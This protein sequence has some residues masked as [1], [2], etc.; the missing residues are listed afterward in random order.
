MDSSWWLASSAACCFK[1]S[2]IT[3]YVLRILE[4]GHDKF[5]LPIIH[6]IE[7]GQSTQTAKVSIPAKKVVTSLLWEKKV[8]LGDGELGDVVTYLE[9]VFRGLVGA[10]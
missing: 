8:S 3:T 2:T 1:Q 5:N 4:I 6:T 7:L 9:A 10:V